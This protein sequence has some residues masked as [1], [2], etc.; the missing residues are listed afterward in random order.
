VVLGVGI[1]LMNLLL[2]TADQWRA[3]CLSILGHSC[4]RTPHLDALARRGVL[5]RRHFSQ[6]TPCGPARASLHTGMY[7][8]NHRSVT[9][10]TPL[11]ARHRDL[12]AEARSRGYRPT[13]FGYTDLGVDPRGRDP[14]DPWLRTY[15]GLYPSFEVALYLPEDNAAWLAHLERRHGHARSLAELF[16]GPLGAPAPYAAE[17]SETAFLTDAFLSWLD[18]WR[19]DAPWFAHLSYIKPHPPLVAPAPYHARY[20]P[21]EVPP[22]VR[23][24]TL[25]EEA[26]AHPWLAAK[27]A[28]PP[29]DSW[30]GKPA[31][32]DEAQTRQARAVY[33]GLIAEV[34]EH[35]GRIV[36]ALRARGELENTVIV[37]TSDHGEMLGDHWLLGKDGFFP[38]A[39]HVPLIVVDPS[40]G[41]ARGRTVEAFTEH[42]DLMPTILER[43]GL[44]VPLQCDGKS[45][46]PWLEG[47]TPA[48]WRE[49][50]HY[51]H[52]FRDVETREFETALGL[53]SER[54]ALA[55]RHGDRFSYVHFNGLP[56]L[57]YDLERD[58]QQFHS[59]TTDPLRAPEVLEQAQAMLTFRMD[60]AER[61]LTGCKLTPAGVIGRF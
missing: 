45:L 11:D 50:A 22:P 21:D 33:Y 15:E 23:A 49:A 24:P 3:E 17:D 30:Y 41:A 51:E 10:G 35:I 59:I 2:I 52:D 42:V 9:N 38:Q 36:A 40:P 6:A 12:A 13:L 5:F 55:V 28:L 1:G 29:D 34:D 53:P 58:P 37:V 26:A 8:M 57:C 47:R 25:A 18:R 27:L 56:A 44:E 16:G 61:R 32:L 60:M 46:M 43:L 31:S 19:D 39:F 20:H 54:C 7:A 4:L 48:G 14:A